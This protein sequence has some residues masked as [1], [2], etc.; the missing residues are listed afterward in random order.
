M[1]AGKN[2]GANNSNRNCL[3]EPFTFRPAEFG[4]IEKDKQ[5]DMI[6]SDML[7]PSES[8]SDSENEG[9]L[10]ISNPNRPLMHYD[11]SDERSSDEDDE[12][13][14]GEKESDNKQ[15]EEHYVGKV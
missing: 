3:V 2:I 5:E 1:Q 13:F 14:E 15:D 12:F 10:T 9:A 11:E 6:P 8:D 4:E 7:P